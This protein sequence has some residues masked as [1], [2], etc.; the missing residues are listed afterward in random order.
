[1]AAASRPGARSRRSPGPALGSTPASARPRPLAR[2]GHAQQARA[3]APAEQAQALGEVEQRAGRL[4]GARPGD[5]ALAVE[6]R[7]RPRRPA[8]RAPACAAR[9]TRRPRPARGARPPRAGPGRAPPRAPARKASPPPGAKRTLVAALGSSDDGR[10][11]ATASLTRGGARPCGCAGRR[12]ACRRPARSRG[13]GRC[14]RTRGRGPWPGRR[15]RPARGAARAAACRRARESR[16]GEPRPSRIRRC[17]RKP[18]SLVVVAAGDRADA[19]VGALERRRPPRRARAPRRP[20]AA[21][22]RRGSSAW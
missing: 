2:V 13:R 1:M 18:S 6:D 14:G 19:P 9:R 20:G 7:R 16:S 3:L 5:Q 17:R 8:A 22:R 21:R 11:V 12:S 4:R 10:L 15:A